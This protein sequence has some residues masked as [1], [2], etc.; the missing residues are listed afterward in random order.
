MPSDSVAIAL[1]QSPAQARLGA[2]TEEHEKLLRDITKKKV[3]RDA[4]E[5]EARDAQSELEAKLS[6]LREAYLTT[7]REL[8]AI[9]DGLLGEDSHLG[10]RDRAR[11]RRFYA[12]LLPELAHE[13]P[14]PSS[15]GSDW[16]QPPWESE[17]PPADDGREAGYS[18][19]KPSAQNAGLLRA[20]F[21]KLAVALHPDKEQDE[22]QREKLTHVMKEVTRAYESGDV[23]RLVELE[24][25]WLAPTPAPAPERE[26]D[27]A[28][29]IGEL[30]SANKELR[31]QLR[32]LTAELKELKQSLPGAAT[33][34]RGARGRAARS[35]LD[36]LLAQAEHE[37]QELRTLRDFTQRFADGDMSVNAFL[38][39]PERAPMAAEDPLDQMLAELLEAM[40]DA[41]ERRRPAPRGRQKRR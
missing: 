30:L 39:G 7:L 22:Q 16:D 21:R 8:K 41:G 18:A 32:G 17:A 13:P 12:M 35:E 4:L 14:P 9:F 34:R 25:S 1:H 5:R 6:P 20:L 40:E 29:R 15:S 31:R 11:V 28:R 33:A 36:E 3:A 26:L 38:V 37:L 27:I 19:H 10:K 2:L 24:R 23:A